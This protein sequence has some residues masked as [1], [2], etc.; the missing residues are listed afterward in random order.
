MVLKKF[1]F[2]GGMIIEVNLLHI[3]WG[4]FGYFLSLI[5]FNKFGVKLLGLL[6]LR[7]FLVKSFS[8]DDFREKFCALNGFGLVKVDILIS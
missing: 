1:I 8:F 5:L 7:R 3:L 2:V 6:N 4:L